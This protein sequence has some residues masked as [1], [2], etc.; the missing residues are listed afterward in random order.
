MHVI[1]GDLYRSIM[2]TFVQHFR[3]LT[4]HF[5][6]PFEQYFGIWKTKR[7]TSV[8]LYQNIEDCMKPFDKAVDWQD[9]DGGEF[10]IFF[11]I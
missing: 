9:S 1:L 7:V 8:C 5:L 10:L 3:Q 4:E 6:R 2:S 11:P